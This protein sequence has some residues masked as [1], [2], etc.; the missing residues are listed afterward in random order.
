MTNPYDNP[1]EDFQP[2]EPETSEVP[3]AVG[4]TLRELNITHV[5]TVD[6]FQHNC[7]AFEW[8]LFAGDVAVGRIEDVRAFLYGLEQVVRNPSEGFHIERLGPPEQH[9]P[10]DAAGSN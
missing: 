3:P 1:N 7:S 8:I 4:L 6:G 2:E 5:I 10:W 9:G